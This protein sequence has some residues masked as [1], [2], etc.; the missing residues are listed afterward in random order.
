MREFYSQSVAYIF[1]HEVLLLRASLADGLHA[2]PAQSFSEIGDLIEVSAFQNED[3]NDT[4]VRIHKRGS[5]S[6]A[7][8]RSG[9]TSEEFRQSVGNGIGKLDGIH[10]RDSFCT[11]GGNILPRCRILSSAQNCFHTSMGRSQVSVISSGTYACLSRNSPFHLCLCFSPT[12]LHSGLWWSAP[13]SR[14]YMRPAFL[15][16]DGL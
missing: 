13:M 14:A 1:D 15:C 7:F 16:D 8:I 11:A 6:Y 9:R 4:P 10:K 2:Q 5:H 12:R 3:I